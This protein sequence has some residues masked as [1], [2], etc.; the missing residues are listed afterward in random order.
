MDEARS[1]R[2]LLATLV[3]DGRPLLSLTGILLLLSGLFAIFLAT[4]REFLPH[5][6][7]FLGMSA[8]DLCRV[9]DCRVVGFMFH[10]R[11]SFGGTLIAIALFYLWLA[12][13]PLAQGHRWAWQT[14][15]ISGAAGFLSFLA[16]LGYGYLDTWHGAATLALLPCFVAGL[17]LASPHAQRRSDPW[18][19]SAKAAPPA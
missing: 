12:A 19:R 5:D 6:I 8:D 16:Y 17:V 1:D 15:A 7:A 13:V 9:A 18:L 10:D 2:G 4:R 3:G 14:F 11:V